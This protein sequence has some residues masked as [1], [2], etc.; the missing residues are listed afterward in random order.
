MS[1]FSNSVDGRTR[2]ALLAR[3]AYRRTGPAGRDFVSP[4]RAPRRRRRPGSDSASSENQA[5]L[6]V[7]VSLAV[8]FPI[9]LHTLTPLM[10][11]GIVAAIVI[12]T[13]YAMVLAA[14]SRSGGRPSRG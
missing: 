9:L 8:L 4:R 6:R 1:S 12:G 10:G 3:T 5:T 11:S 13:V 7:C 14:R 2:N